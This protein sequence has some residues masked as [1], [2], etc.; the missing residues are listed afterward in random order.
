M[1]VK[2]DQHA[3]IE[4]ILKMFVNQQVTINYNLQHILFQY[5]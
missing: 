1:V 2:H 5:V 3:Q 4:A